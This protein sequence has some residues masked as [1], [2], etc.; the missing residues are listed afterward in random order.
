MVSGMPLLF[1]NIFAD[2][3]V[4]ILLCGII[5]HL[6][7][8]GVVSVTQWMWPHPHP[9]HCFI[10]CFLNLCLRL[11]TKMAVESNLWFGTPSNSPGVFVAI[12]ISSIV[13]PVEVLWVSAKFCKTLVV[14][15]RV[16]NLAFCA[17]LLAC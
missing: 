4:R 13:F 14:L 9:C 10:V 5:T 1:G 6:Q 3:L 17:M 7:V 12:L 16:T 8:Q 2:R 15:T 11:I